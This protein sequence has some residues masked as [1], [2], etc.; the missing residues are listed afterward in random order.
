[1]LILENIKMAFG[2][3]RAN[4]MRS[5]LTMLGIIIGV[6]SVIAIMT[7]SSSLKGSI[8]DSFQDLGANNIMVSVSEKEDDED[9]DMSGLK[10]G[11]DKKDSEMKEQDLIS[12]EMVSDLK[13]RYKKS[14]DAVSISEEMGTGTL[15]DKSNSA[16]IS[17]TAINSEYFKTNSVDLLVGRYINAADVAAGKGVVMISD[18]AAETIFGKN[19]SDALCKKVSANINNVYYD[20]YVVGVY[21]HKN[22]ASSMMSMSND[23]STK[24]YMPITT[25]KAKLHGDKGYSMITLITKTTEENVNGVADNVESYMNTEYYNSNRNF[26]ISATTMSTIV[27]MMD[28]LLDKVS[29]AIAVIAGISLLVGGIG[30]MNIMLVSV[31]ERTREIGTRKALGAK[32]KSIRLQFIIESITLCVVG[33]IIGIILGLVFGMLAA[34]GLGFEGTV[35]IGSIFLSVGTSML[36]GVFFGYYPANKAA[37]MN[38]IEALRHD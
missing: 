33:G 19:Y 16:D 36:I 35:P 26:E 10:F 32:N 21:K 4:K 8:L 22:D 6:S 34:K 12:D 25:A 2:S 17:V 7:V 27:D 18:E 14:I 1:M 24:V 28:E 29:T 20:F 37:K 30:V 9:S 11:A 13:T 23:S 5:F 3:L 15:E 38:P 31:T